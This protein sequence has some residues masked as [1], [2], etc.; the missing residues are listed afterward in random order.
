ME[1]LSSPDA[2]VRRWTV[3][4]L[5]ESTTGVF[6]DR[7]IDSPRLTAELLLGRV[8]GIDRI[9]IYTHFDRPVD[10]QE[11]RTFRELVRRRI[12][13]EP[14]QYIL[15]ETG[16]MGLRFEVNNDVL[17][18]RPETELLVEH[19]VALEKEHP[20]SVRNILDIG[21]GS[22]N[23]ALSLLRMIPGAS[24]DAVDVS[25][26]ALEVAR[27]NAL[28]LGVAD[29]VR[30]LAGD[31]LDDE[32][33]TGTHS[34]D[35]VASNPPYISAA[36]FRLLD[37]EVR[38]F[39]PALATTDGGDGLTFYRVIA[40]RSVS[41]L[42]PGGSCLVEVAYNQHEAVIELFRGAGLTRISTLHDYEGIPRIVAGCRGEQE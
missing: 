32:Y 23:I 42:R 11:I 2:P 31:I 12:A 33:S 38:D 27:R 26:R 7:G 36:E 35:L 40:K 28:A 1:A 34:Y 16:F 9:G 14:V 21:T 41:F 3:L 18:P 6:A 8:L 17:I 15:G 29:R 37:P 10:P 20:G 4:A 5:V 19:V 13:H 22:G 25:A 39:E 30:F 24:A